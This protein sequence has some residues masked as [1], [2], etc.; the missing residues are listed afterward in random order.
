[1]IRKLVLVSSVRGYKAH[2]TETCG[3]DQPHLITHVETTA[4]TIQDEQVTDPIHQALEAKDLLPKEHLL[5]RGYVNTNVLINSQEQY[6]V[7]VIGPIKVDTTWQPN[8]A[9]GSTCRAL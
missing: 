4:A 2:L 1:M 7:E 8:R 6:G 3:E 5:D 9:K